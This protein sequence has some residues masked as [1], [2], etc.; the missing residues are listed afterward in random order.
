MHLQS[1]YYPWSG[2]PNLNLE[3]STGPWS[4][5][6]KWFSLPN[7]NL[8]VNKNFV[9]CGSNTRVHVCQIVCPCVYEWNQ[10][11]LMSSNTIRSNFGQLLKKLTWSSKNEVSIVL[12]WLSIE[13]ITYVS[14][15]TGQ[16]LCRE[17]TIVEW[18]IASH[19]SG[20]EQ[21]WS[22]PFAKDVL[23]SNHG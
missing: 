8:E 14:I 19:T 11:L 1:W 17:P 10:F 23:V 4:D 15:V 6:P 5:R 13:I 9:Y 18:W 16:K 3:V 20:L 12:S 2:Q 21:A 7:L 22:T